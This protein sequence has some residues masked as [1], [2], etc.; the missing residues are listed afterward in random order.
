[1]KKSQTV[2]NYYVLPCCL[3]LLN[4]GNNLVAYKAGMITDPSL[5]VVAIMAMILFG[6]TVVAFAL[7]PAIETVV[8]TLH[9]SS[10]RQAG[11]LGEIV[12][13]TVLGVFVFWLYYRFYV[14]GPE[15]LLPREWWNPKMGSR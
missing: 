4:L 7:S 11:M 14:T 5:R 12:F 9:R 2:R 13:L 15:A 8:R 3:L 10:S 6:G 1:M